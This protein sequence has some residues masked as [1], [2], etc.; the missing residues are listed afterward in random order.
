MTR[1]DS[2][3]RGGGGR[4][5]EM[6]ILVNITFLGGQIHPFLFFFLLNINI[7]HHSSSVKYIRFLWK[8]FA[9]ENYEKKIEERAL[10][11]QRAIRLHRE[12]VL[13]SFF[14]LMSVASKDQ[15]CYLVH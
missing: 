13:A 5:A 3:T 9:V 8:Y 15:G 10:E 1:D 6:T 2:A 4:N 14:Y 7:R 12:G 11:S